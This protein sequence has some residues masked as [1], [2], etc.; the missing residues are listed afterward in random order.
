MMT[1]SKHIINIEFDVNAIRQTF[2]CVLFV[3]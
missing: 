3:C 2:D 1:V